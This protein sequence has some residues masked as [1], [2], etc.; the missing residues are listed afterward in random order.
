MDDASVAGY[1][2]VGRGVSGAPGAKGPLGAKAAY[3][4]RDSLSAGETVRVP[5]ETV[6]APMVNC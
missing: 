1:E 4:L 2:G 3:L 6:C 5:G